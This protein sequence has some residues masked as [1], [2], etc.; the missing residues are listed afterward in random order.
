MAPPV[1]PITGMPQVCASMMTRPNCS[2][3]RV[4]RSREQD[5][6]VE[7]AH[8]L[9]DLMRR[10]PIAKAHA[11]AET[12]LRDARAQ[13]AFMRAG[14]DQIEADTGLRARDRIQHIIESLLL[15]ETADI[16][17]AQSR[18]PRRRGSVGTKAVLIHAIA[19]HRDRSLIAAGPHHG[20]GVRAARENMRA[21][22]QHEAANSLEGRRQG[23][24]NVLIDLEHERRILLRQRGLQ[25]H[26]A[27]R[28]F[29]KMK[30]MRPQL[31]QQAREAGIEVQ[32][33]VQRPS[34]RKQ[35]RQ[36]MQLHR[37]IGCGL[38]GERAAEL[39][40]IFRHDEMQIEIALPEQG[41]VALPS[42]FLA[43][44]GMRDGNDA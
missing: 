11:V 31:A 29:P 27:P 24:E 19:D 42:A 25:R 43:D 8:E 23:F 40:P 32:I 15:D 33:P 18:A 6:R 38:A 41:R 9:R 30:H 20:L 3:T 28:L 4:R 5:Q 16:A 14:S 22:L 35:D 26:H 12:E 21:F 44:G 10:R 39:T 34:A 36:H 2:R 13:F 17:D 37:G 1:D 7:P